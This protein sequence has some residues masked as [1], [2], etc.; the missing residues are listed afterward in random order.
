MIEDKLT[1]YK[2]S[3]LLSEQIIDDN[4][5]DLFKNN[6]YSNLYEID[7]AVMHRLMVANKI[8]K[9]YLELLLKK[10]WFR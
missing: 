4:Y 1:K 6:P 8:Y 5:W 3:E 2:I 10:E 9:P 7:D